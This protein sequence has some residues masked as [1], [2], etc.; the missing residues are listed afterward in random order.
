MTGADV[1]SDHNMVKT[2]I[3]I[4]LKRNGSNT[5][6]R[7]CCGFRKLEDTTTQQKY[8]IA[9]RNRFPTLQHLEGVDRG[10]C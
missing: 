9:V 7:K 1:G 10:D 3:R 6:I 4:K 8:N 2:R 5:Q